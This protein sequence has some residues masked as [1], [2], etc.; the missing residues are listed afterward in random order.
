MRLHSLLYLSL[1]LMAC[2]PDVDE[3]ITQVSTPRILAVRGI[4]AEARPSTPVRYEALIAGPDGPLGAGARFSYC[5][6]ARSA[7]ERT[8]VSRRC[9]Q[10]EALLDV[11]TVVPPN[12]CALF[13]PNT[14]PSADGEPARRPSDPDP[15]G[16]Y[17]IPVLAQDS[18][19]T[20]PPTFGFQ[21]I[22]C[23]LAG[24]TRDIFEQYQ[25]R[26]RENRHPDISRLR[27]GAEDLMAGRL[28]TLPAAP[29]TLLMEVR[30][31]SFERFVVYSANDSALYD[32]TEELQ[33]HWYASAGE[34]SASEGLVDKNSRSA[35]VQWTGPEA[36]E[37]AR[38]WII[39]RDS[40]GGSVWAEYE[41]SMAPAP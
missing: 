11:G 16:G 35:S 38:L 10:G 12:A 15:S 1:P 33:V 32:Q 2:V 40:R 27:A 5:T 41:V 19:G 23:D 9:L 29:T 14:P 34:F 3:A 22:R 13:G 8:G 31:D 17:F 39:V 4:P 24:A 21:R 25:A 20:A 28:R 6:E 26:Y 37:T 30:A 36:G 18:A 7:E